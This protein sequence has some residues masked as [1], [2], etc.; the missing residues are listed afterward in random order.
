MDAESVLA[1]DEHPAQQYRPVRQDVLD[2]SGLSDDATGESWT[3]ETAVLPP[4]P[5]LADARPAGETTSAQ[6]GDEVPWQ[7]AW[8][9]A[10]SSPAADLATPTDQPEEAEVGELLVAEALP[11]DDRMALVGALAEAAAG[12]PVE[13]AAFAFGEEL[14][15]R[16]S[17]GPGV[18]A[19]QRALTT[20][21]TPLAA[22]GDFGPLTEQ[23]VRRFQSS[24]GLTVDGVVGPRTKAALTVALTRR[25][26][27][28]APGPA[29]APAPA[30]PAGP[31]PAAIARVA[32][33]ELADRKSVV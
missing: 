22:D 24:A 27:A 3:D 14:L 18:V 29:P 33:A 13:V 30:P 26:S 32:E 15:R 21:G 20:L 19:L 23:A 17:R 1:L 12:S 10:P 7:Q 8:Y 9:E 31:L 16:G 11:F 28:P 6:S 2:L 25:G 5:G 4:G